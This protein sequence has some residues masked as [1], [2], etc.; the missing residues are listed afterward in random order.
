MCLFSGTVY[1]KPLLKDGSC[2]T[3]SYKKKV[4]AERDW[5]LKDE[6]MI[7]DNVSPELEDSFKPL[8]FC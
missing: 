7:N 8:A 6:W 2:F 4:E 1:L 5:F 3:E